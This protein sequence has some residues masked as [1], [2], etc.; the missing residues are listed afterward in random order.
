MSAQSS[1][2]IPPLNLEESEEFEFQNC[3]DEEDDLRREVSLGY[4]GIGSR[5]SDISIDDRRDRIKNLI[6][7]IYNTCPLNQGNPTR[8]SLN[9]SIKRYAS[10][11]TVSDVESV[12]TNQRPQRSSHPARLTRHPSYSSAINRAST[13]RKYASSPKLNTPKISV[14]NMAPN[15][16]MFAKIPLSSASS[17]INIKSSNKS[18]Q[19]LPLRKNVS[20][21]EPVLKKVSNASSA[22]SE[23]IIEENEEETIKN[24]EDADEQDDDCQSLMIRGSDIDYV[25]ANIQCASSVGHVRRKEFEAAAAAEAE[26]KKKKSE[27]MKPG[28]KYKTGSVPKYLEKRQAA[29]KAQAEK[30]EREKPDPDCPVGHRKLSDG[31]R[32]EALGQMR[33]RYKNLL[34]QANAF[35]VRADTLRVKQAKADIESEMRTLEDSIR[36]Y[37]RPKVFVKIE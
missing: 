8:R 10:M 4:L 5:F 28:D 11:D 26:R 23:E 29:W 7:E 32:R 34:D 30:I 3:G 33:E 20:N 6:N 16:Q 24:D 12:I 14:Q 36:T 21:P 27:Q 15:P 22:Q 13:L 1:V 18:D 31:D 25:R 35:P 9:Q 17:M 19:H 2:A 37:E